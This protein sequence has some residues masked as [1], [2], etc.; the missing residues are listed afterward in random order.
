MLQ[1]QYCTRCIL[2][3]TFGIWLCP[4]GF[5]V[6]K[7]QQHCSLCLSYLVK[8]VYTRKVYRKVA[9]YIPGWINMCEDP[10]STDC[11]SC[12]ANASVLPL[13][14][15]VTVISE[16]TGSWSIVQQLNDT[17]VC[18]NFRALFCQCYQKCKCCPGVSRES[19]S[20]GLVLYYT[21]SKLP[22]VNCW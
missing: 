20:Q 10:E 17:A 19:Y 11:V 16:N 7:K 8:A 13:G 18:L 15:L 21:F 12:V 2:V 9:M 22:L 3:L 5:Y 14:V 6:W 4:N 1:C